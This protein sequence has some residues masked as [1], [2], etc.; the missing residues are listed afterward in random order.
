MEGRIDYVRS[1]LANHAQLFFSDSVA[2]LLR[3]DL[4]E[5][6]RYA[7]AIAARECR[8]VIPIDIP[9]P[10]RPESV[11]RVTFND[12][13]VTVWNRLPKPEGADWSA[14]P[15]ETAPLWY[16]HASGTLIPAWNLI[17]NLFDLL[18]FG[19]EKRSGQRDQHGRFHWKSSPRAA[20]GLLGVPA[21]NEAVA[22]LI[23]AL[24][25]ASRSEDPSF[26]LNTSPR[27]PIVVLSHDCDMLKG[28]D[29]TT[30]A[31]RLY[32]VVSP[33]MKGKLP[34]I[35][36]VW[37]IFRNALL[38]RQYYFDNVTGMIDIERCFGGRS[39][40]YLLNGTG[41]RFGARTPFS[42]VIRLRDHVP[43]AW[44]IGIHY[45]YDT[46]LNHERFEAQLKQLQGIVTR[47]I[48]SGRAHYLRFDPFRSFSFLRGFGI[49]VDESSG[50]S[51]KVAFRNGIAGCFQAYDLERDEPLDIWEVP[52]TVMDDA[53]VN[54]YGGNALP[55][56]EQQLDHLS[57]IGGALT[58]L[59]HPGQF[60]NPEH[61]LTSGVYHKILIACRRAQAEI[62]TAKEFV[63][64]VRK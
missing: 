2:G 19:E 37:W 55:A 41:G 33:L 28:N 14:L 45:N 47:P 36:N 20:E 17:G 49:Y 11:S 4:L 42:E 38:P 43:P 13:S 8:V 29:L 59:F 57:K 12:T 15:D 51:D 53:L 58:I 35:G 46:F 31:I 10:A 61:P 5:F 16:R 1:Q 25:S 34:K 40:L 3:S 23:D 27:K 63:D 39:A 44:E 30:Q 50:W 24:D 56:I 54:E 7:E 9:I 21:V 52:M 26:R 64:R 22:V 48:V 62:L 6:R 60:A 18:T 32:R